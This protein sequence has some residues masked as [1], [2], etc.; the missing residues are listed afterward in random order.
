MSTGID[1]SFEPSV[2]RARQLDESMRAQLAES[3]TYLAR[4]MAPFEQIDREQLAL[5]LQRLQSFSVAPLTFTIYW[6]IVCAVNADDLES[7]AKLFPQLLQQPAWSSGLQVIDLGD[8]LSNPEAERYARYIDGDPDLPL[9]LLPPPA[10]AAARTRQLIENA[11]SLMQAGDPDLAGEIMTLLRAI[12][13]CA[14]SPTPGRPTFDGASSLML[15][16][17]IL[18]NAERQGDALSTV[19]MLA[20]ESAHNLLFG[21][22]AENRLLENDA[23]ER[24]AS[25]LR[26]DPRPLEGIFHATFVSARMYRSMRQLVA[27]ATLSPEE[28]ALAEKDAVLN[29]KAFLDGA[30][31]L[32][33]HAEFTE[34]GRSILENARSYVL[35]S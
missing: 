30:A 9:D 20:H 6:D 13:L 23:S 11:F 22:T 3:I 4:K 14:A 27:S 17:A 7:A 12:V 10:E 25:P 18:I 34:T 32:D 29:K 21:F 1:F 2:A 26:V 5:F 33:R 31:T 15:W 8:K 19:Q 28:T 16:G 24:Y 35:S